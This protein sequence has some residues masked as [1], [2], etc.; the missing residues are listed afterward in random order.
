MAI[1]TEIEALNLAS[2]EFKLAIRYAN[3]NREQFYTVLFNTLLEKLVKEQVDKEN[4]RYEEFKKKVDRGWL[5]YVAW[6]GLICLLEGFD[7]YMG[8]SLLGI[9][10]IANT[11][12]FVSIFQFLIV[13]IA[14]FQFE[15]GK[16]YR[17]MAAEAH[18]E[19]VLKMIENISYK[20]FFEVLDD[21]HQLFPDAKC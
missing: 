21:F 4:K 17:L 12:F 10:Y 9:E 13:G 8:F 3:K 6:G 2:D 19:H 20:H 5:M 1:K 11:N 16:Y 18:H 14:L 7:M 15:I